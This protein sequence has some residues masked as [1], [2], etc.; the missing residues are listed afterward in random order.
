MFHYKRAFNHHRCNPDL[1][2]IGDISRTR[3]RLSAGWTLQR[4]LLAARLTV[5]ISILPESFQHPGQLIPFSQTFSTSAT[6]NSDIQLNVWRA[7]VSGAW[8]LWISPV[9]DACLQSSLLSER[10]SSDFVTRLENCS[11][12]FCFKCSGEFSINCM[13]RCFFLALTSAKL[14][15]EFY[16]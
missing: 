4:S 16:S 1:A 15:V 2:S 14:I 7:W 10:L 6:G 9:T 5:L 11:A 8:T 12:H 13:F 3:R